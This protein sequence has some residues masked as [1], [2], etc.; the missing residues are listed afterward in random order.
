MKSIN[1]VSDS[2]AGSRISETLET[3]SSAGRNR[4]IKRR[5]FVCVAGLVAISGI[6]YLF[7]GNGDGKIQYSTREAV[8]GSLCVT[9]TATGNLEPTNQ[10]DVGSELSGTVRHVEVDYNSYVKM[11]QVLA[12]LDTS[13]LQAQA[14]QS[15]ASLESAQAKVLQAQATVREAR[16]ELGRLRRLRELNSKALSQHDLD[17][18]EA[19]LARAVADEASCKAE[20]SRN[21]ATLE[22]NET[23]LSKAVIRSPINGVVLTRSVEPGQTVA[24]GLSTPVLFTLAE[25]LTKM[26]LL[27]DVDEADVGAVRD[28]QDASFTVDAFPD[29]RYPA[30]IVQVRYGAKTKNSVVT[31]KAALNVDNADLSLR[32]G[33]TA[34]AEITVRRIEDAVLAPNAA[35]RFT[36]P[37]E[38]EKS[39]TAGRQ[40]AGIMS[41][42]LPR[43]PAPPAKKAESPAGAVKGPCVWI[44]R[45][46]GRLVAVPVVT[47][48]TDGNFT[49]L[50]G[51]AV[52]PGTLLVVDMVKEK[53]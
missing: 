24:A 1:S 15:K 42:L 29:R 33:M 30:R 40:R 3:G 9:V 17:A 8:R 19:T 25:D 10:V 41:K 43:P 36:P 48:A 44:V 53:R 7:A 5:I 31:Y 46:D 18:G 20:V 14:L 45:N 39:E 23:D 16:N 38:E 37:A 49:A 47:D 32:P 13:K 4:S 26:K 35:L 2:A 27:V 51:G 50:K 21:K 34:T 52:E 11:G 12:R 28:G 6:V 22:A